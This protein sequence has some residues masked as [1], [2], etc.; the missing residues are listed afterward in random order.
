MSATYTKEITEIVPV[1]RVNT[2][3][4]PWFSAKLST[5]CP[6]FRTKQSSRYEVDDLVRWTRKEGGCVS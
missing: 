6:P 5:E 4:L 2:R 1:K 3:V